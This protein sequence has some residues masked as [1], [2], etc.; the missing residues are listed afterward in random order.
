MAVGLGGKNTFNPTEDLSHKSG[1]VQFASV[2]KKD[3]CK[4][5]G[6]G[7]FSLFLQSEKNGEGNG[8]QYFFVLFFFKGTK[9]CILCVIGCPK[10]RNYPDLFPSLPLPPRTAPT[11]TTTMSAFTMAASAGAST[12]G[13]SGSTHVSIQVPV[14]YASRTLAILSF[15]CV[16]L[17]AVC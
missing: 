12:H 1:H 7:R 17:G 3:A 10:S 8:F 11:P 5:V 6:S 16:L 15:P 9:K 4:R 13:G 2:S 14:R